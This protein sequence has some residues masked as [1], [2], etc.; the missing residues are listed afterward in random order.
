MANDHTGIS[1]T[2]ATW[3]PVVG[4]TRVS[5]GCERCYAERAVNRLQRHPVVGE[6]YQGLLTSTG[7]FSGRVA[8]FWDRFDQPLRWKRPRKIFVNSMSDLFH[9]AIS[10][11]TRD[12]LFGVMALADRHTF[13]ILTKRAAA[14]REYFAEPT[15]MALIE[16]AA[17]LLYAER[18]PGDDPSMWLAVSELPKNI[19]LGISA[20]DQRRADARIPDLLETPARV[21]FVS[22]EPLIGPIVLRPEWLHGLDTSEGARDPKRV[23]WIIAGGE[24]GPDAREC[25]IDWLEALLEQTLE[26]PCAFWMKQLGSNPI[27][28]LAQFDAMPL[29]DRITLDLPGGRGH[30]TPID[31]KGESREGWPR[32]LNVQEFPEPW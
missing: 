24:S 15:R 18:N 3:S 25:A 16:G 22:A 21:R 29:G 30:I 14:M 20:E 31:R 1:W 10:D 11:E 23:D 6:H 9:D 12:T 2:D 27:G 28:T 4:C 17:Q 7:R 19:W 8:T 32:R 5:P 13:Q 26:T